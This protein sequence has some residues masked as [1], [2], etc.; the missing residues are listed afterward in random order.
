M[1]TLADSV[2]AMLEHAELRFVFDAEHLMVMPALRRRVWTP[3]EIDRLVDEREDLTPRYELV[4]GEL[5][6]TA[7]PTDHHQRI[8]AEL[9]APLREYVNRERIGEVRLGPARARI[10]AGARFE[11]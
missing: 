7:A 8:V 11:P 9:F 6:V 2:A 1:V 5:L 10:A 4:D 3:D